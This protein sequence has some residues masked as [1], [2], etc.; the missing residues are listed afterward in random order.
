[1]ADGLG[2]GRQR[3]RVLGHSARRLLPAGGRLRD[4]DWAGRHRLLTHLLAACAAALTV[5]GLLTDGL[6]L[7][8]GIGM[9]LIAPCMAGAVALPPRRLPSTC[10]A[11][12]FTVACAVFVTMCHGL[13]EAHFTFFIA[14]GALALYRDWTPFGAFLVGTVLHHALFGSV[15]MAQAF[16]HEQA[17]HHPMVWAAL[18]GVAVLAAATVQVVAW[19]L[20]EAEEDRAQEN[21]LTSQAQLDIAFDRTPVPMV[22][23]APDGRITRTNDAYRRWLGLPDRLPDGFGVDDLPLTL[24]EPGVPPMPEELTGD[25]TS[26]TEV[27]HYR[28]HDDGSVIWVEVHSS[29]L[30]DGDGR[31][32]LLFVQYIDVTRARRHA[33]ELRRQIRE[34][35]LTGLLSRA[36]F[37]ADLPQLLADVDGP[38]SVVYA[39]VD[40]FKVINDANGHSHGDEALR[41]LA[42]RMQ[43]LVPADTLLARVGGDEFVLASPGDADAVRGLAQAVLEACAEPIDLPSG[44]LV[45]GV[46]VGVAT[47]A[48][49]SQAERAVADS[50]LAML[51]AKRTGGGR[52]SVFDERMRLATERRI[53]A[54]AQLRSALTASP[55]Q[56]ATRLPVWFQPIVSP[57]DDRIVGAEA[58]VRMTGPDGGLVPPGAFIPVAEE[59]GLIV[60]LGEHVLRTAVDH[61]ELWQDRLGYVSVNVSPRQLAEPGF[62]PMLARV[63]AGTDLDPSRIVLEITETAM[64][65]TGVDLAGTLS[66]IKALGVRLALDDFGTGYSSLTWLQSVPADIVK[67]DRSFVSGLAGDPAKATIIAGVLWLARSL[68][69]SAVAEGVEDRADWDALRDADCPAIQGYLFSPPRDAAG[70]AGLL[71]ASG[72][73]LPGRPRH[74]VEVG[75]GPDQALAR[76]MGPRVPTE[77]LDVVR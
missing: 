57:A 62:V 14:V 17:Y 27:R 19:R 2:R 31:L 42:L 45:L 44:R 22:L 54:E 32:K 56:R 4:A 30:L 8:W 52:L 47:A 15:L 41:I 43:G 28:R 29:P 23:I 26:V 16:D 64:L 34:D 71:A 6:D 24:I 21:L 69:M 73:P 39:D 10:V 12:G 72:P 18:H 5:F 67:L 59:T 77:G 25:G 51:H 66:R 35:A 49:P 70:M 60:P 76:M 36:A 37:E 46:S 40:R 58:L 38:V 63:L 48:D 13:T 61:L 68:G 33:V 9:L 3:L 53:E 74:P 50:D 7:A 75:R 11:L 20:A 55:L 65:A 1:M